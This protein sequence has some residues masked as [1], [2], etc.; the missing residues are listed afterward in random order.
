MLSDT[1]ASI[2]SAS[3]IRPAAR[4]SQRGWQAFLL[5]LISGCVTAVAQDDWNTPHEP[6]RIFGNTY[7][8]GTAGLSA[9]LIT[10][11]AG[12]IL[13]DGGLLQSVPLI[14]ANIRELGFE[15]TATFT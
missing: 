15:P 10:S 11:N 2:P 3:E 13:I 4:K 9:I 8:V 1:V 5:L 14:A 12:H 6:F 7:Y